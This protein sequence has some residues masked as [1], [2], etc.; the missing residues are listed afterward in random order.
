MNKPPAAGSLSPVVHE[1]RAMKTRMQ[2]IIAGYPKPDLHSMAFILT[3][4]KNTGLCRFQNSVGSQST[5]QTGNQ[6]G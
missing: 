1:K 6:A 3:G 2:I 4:R 5:A